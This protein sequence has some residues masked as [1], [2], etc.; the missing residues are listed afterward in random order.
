MLLRTAL[1]VIA[2]AGLLAQVAT[3]TAQQTVTFASAGAGSVYHS[4]GG[5]IAKIISEKT[6]LQI[7]LKAFGGSSEYLPVVNNGEVEFGLANVY[8]TSLAVQGEDYFKGRPTKDLRAVAILYP[9]RNSVFVRKDSDIKTVADLKGKRG[10]AGFASQKIL[11]SVTNAV[12]GTSGLSLVDIQGVDVANIVANAD[13]FAAGRTDFFV[14][15]LG[16]PK[17]K[18]IDAAV[19]G[20]RALPIPNTPE[21]LAGTRK[22]VPVSYLRREVPSPA[23]TGIVEPTHQV[24]Y[25]AM[26]FAS[27]K[28]PDALVE[29]V[30]TAM[31]DNAKE[32]R[33][34]VAVMRLFSIDRMATQTPG[35]AYHPAAVAYYKKINKW[36]APEN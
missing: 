23:A 26:L 9:L 33:E 34:S 36:Q 1:P 5:A 6:G 16:A 7:N 13:A 19:G 32:L 27:T 11:V 15:A 10:P 29:K 3:A 12:L 21:A 8:E 30:L 14:F 2:I 35:V 18:E 25:D 24:A 22:Y 17:V 31:H 28:T 20:V 4:S